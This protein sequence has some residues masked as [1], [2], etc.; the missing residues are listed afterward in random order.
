[1]PKR[2]RSG[3]PAVTPV[4]QTGLQVYVVLKMTVG[5]TSELDVAAWATHA[6]TLLFSPIF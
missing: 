6:T 1:M 5:R 4:D 3:P 2:L